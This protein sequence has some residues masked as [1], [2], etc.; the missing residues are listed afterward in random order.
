M[1]VDR[2]RVLD[3]VAQQNLLPKS[4]WHLCKSTPQ[5]PFSTRLEGQMNQMLSTQIALLKRPH[6]KTLSLNACLEIPIPLQDGLERLTLHM[7]RTAD[8]PAAFPSSLK[9]VHMVKSYRLFPF[10]FNVGMYMSRL[11]PDLPELV[12]C[13]NIL[14]DDNDC[15]LPIG[16]QRLVL[17]DVDGVPPSM[18]DALQELTVIGGCV[19]LDLPP[20]LKTLIFRG[21]D[22]CMDCTCVAHCQQ[23][24]ELQELP[25]TLETLEITKYKVVHLPLLPSSLVHLELGHMTYDG[26]LDLPDTLLTAVL[27]RGFSHRIIV[28]PLLQKLVF[29]MSGGYNHALSLPDTLKVLKLPPAY[30]HPLGVPPGLE[31]LGMRGNRVF[32]Q[33]LPPLPTSLKTLILDDG[34]KHPF[35]ALPPSLRHLRLGEDYQHPLPAHNLRQL[36]VHISYKHR[37]DKITNVY[38]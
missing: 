33:R 5:M 17:Q 22:Q 20:A 2:E 9:S 13:G 11:P 15:T 16:L 10:R 25:S 4:A 35:E 38:L 30:D 12:L 37:V 29:S 18:P 32:A 36:H 26:P 3:L 21:T 28:P 31:V 24:L 6:M 19:D 14:D 27:P 23:T 8:L 1:Q 7:D 34:Y